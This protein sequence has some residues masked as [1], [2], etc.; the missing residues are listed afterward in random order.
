LKFNIQNNKE[1][2]MKR[3]LWTIIVGFLFLL[4]TSN[5]LFGQ[6]Q[7]PPRKTPELLAQGKKLYEQNCLPCHGAKGDGRGPAGVAL[8]PPPQDFNIPFGRWTYSKGDIKKVFD[9]ISKG[10][11]N[12]AMIK[13]DYLSE[14]DRWA[15]VYYVEG[16]A[17]PAKKK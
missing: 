8:Q 4:S 15:L 10:I 17:T 16:F 1:E 14:Q 7:K 13:W 5:S 9:V 12:T 11:P 2:K 6:A 3:V